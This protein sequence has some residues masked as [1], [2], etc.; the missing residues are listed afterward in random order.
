MQLLTYRSQKVD[1]HQFKQYLDAMSEKVELLLENIVP[2]GSSWSNKK[3]EDRMTKQLPSKKLFDDIHFGKDVLSD[4]R[5]VESLS[6]EKICDQLLKID[7]QDQDFPQNYLNFYV[8]E[9]VPRS[10][11]K[12]TGRAQSSY[13]PKRTLQGYQ[14][15]SPQTLQ[16]ETLKSD[17][18][19]KELDLDALVADANISSKGVSILKNR[20]KSGQRSDKQLIIKPTRSQSSN[21]KIVE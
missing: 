19:N 21:P 17:Q 12:T 10:A 2:F 16:N 9:T 8:N 18:S 1:Q 4:A 14:T 7:I 6:I 3:L 15:Q 20:M 11:E 13:G 5:N